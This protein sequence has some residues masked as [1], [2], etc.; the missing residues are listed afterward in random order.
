[1]SIHVPILYV[2][3]VEVHIHFDIMSS[4]LL[5]SPTLH[6][7][8]QNGKSF[9]SL[10]RGLAWSNACT[11]LSSKYAPW[12]TRQMSSLWANC[13]QLSAM[14]EQGNFSWKLG[15]KKH[16]L[17]NRLQNVHFGSTTILL[18]EV[19]GHRTG[20]CKQGVMGQI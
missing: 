9:G 2:T 11:S 7:Q 19:K 15:E 10:F 14:S 5:H 3:A 12:W 16:E 13:S 6:P 8:R 1:M 17:R 18:S 20:K 4:G